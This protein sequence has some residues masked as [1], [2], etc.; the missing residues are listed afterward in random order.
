MKALRVWMGHF[1]G[2]GAAMRFA[3]GCFTSAT[4]LFIA[5]GIG[6]VGS[7]ALPVS[8]VA[9]LVAAIVGATALEHGDPVVDPRRAQPDVSR[10]SMTNTMVSVPAI[11]PSGEPSG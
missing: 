8:G 2:N 7:W 1:V 10:M 9:L 6:A 11:D 5:G 4:V 3:A